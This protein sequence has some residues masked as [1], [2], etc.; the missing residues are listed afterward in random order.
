MDSDNNILQELRRGNDFVLER[1]YNDF[2]KEFIGWVYKN[3]H[4]SEEDAKDAYQM[5]F[6]IFYQ[7]VRTG[8]LMNINS[9][10]KTYIFSLGKNK[11][12]E[13]YRY[14]KRFKF[15]I[16]DNMLT[17]EEDFEIELEHNEKFER[18]SKG[19]KEMGE[20][21]KSILVKT[22]YQ[23]K[24]MSEIAQEMGYKNADTSKNL[25]YKCL[26]RLKKIVQAIKV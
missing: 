24:N 10:L 5:A 6:F 17:E 21:C 11:V 23:H 1:T 18:I 8:K 14:N 4:C 13:N 9:S 15:E 12:L 25:K 22:Y 2:R 16:H 7:Q 26:Q 3:Y 19:L 20:P